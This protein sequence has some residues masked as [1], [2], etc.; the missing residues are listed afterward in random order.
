MNGLKLSVLS[1]KDIA[2][3]NE[4]SL[5]VLETTGISVGHAQTRDFLAKQGCDVDKKT[6]IV[7]IPR[8]LVE[9]AISKAPSAFTF[10][11]RWCARKLHEPWNGNK[12]LPLPRKKL[13]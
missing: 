13:I 1:K 9:E 8:S 4:A 2:Q 10:H 5:E 3:I 7:K 6:E 11:Q 12:D